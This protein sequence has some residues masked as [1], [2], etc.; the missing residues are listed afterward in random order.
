MLN[1]IITSQNLGGKN[2]KLRTE[3]CNLRAESPLIL[4][5]YDYTSVFTDDL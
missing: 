3:T 2:Q 5:D 4:S 1:G